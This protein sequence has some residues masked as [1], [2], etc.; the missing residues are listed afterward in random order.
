M[1][2]GCWLDELDGLVFVFLPLAQTSSVAHPVTY[3]VC[4]FGLFPWG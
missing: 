4:F 3:P 1:L 2:A